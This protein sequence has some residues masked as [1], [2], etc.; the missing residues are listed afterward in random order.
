MTQRKSLFERIKVGVLILLAVP[1]LLILLVPGL[2]LGIPAYWLYGRWL[3]VR[4]EQ[5]WGRQ[6][7]RILLVYSRS[8]NW[9]AYIENSGLPRVAPYAVVIDWSDRS[10]WPR[11]APLEIRAF[12]YWGRPARV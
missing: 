10:T 4:W 2:L 12:R 8:P 6:G 1:V 5:T 3:K 9:Q 7:K 11:R